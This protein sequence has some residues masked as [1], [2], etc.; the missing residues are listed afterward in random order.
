[1]T[2]AHPT[3]RDAVLANLRAWRTWPVRL[4]RLWRRSLRFRTIVVTIA[5]SSLA[6][7]VASVWMAIAIQN[8][9]FQSRR[10]QVLSDARRAT[11]SAQETFDSA[12]QSDTAQARTLMES[13]RGNLT[14]QSSSDLVSVSRIDPSPSALAPQDFTLGGD[15][16]AHR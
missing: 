12:A 5:L 13:V 9:L 7:L 6:I 14:R 2:A 10:D 16:D 3:R 4:A 11:V 1:M 8:D 15:W